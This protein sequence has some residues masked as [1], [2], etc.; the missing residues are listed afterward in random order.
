M[1]KLGY[2]GEEYYKYMLEREEKS[3]TYIGNNVAI[4]HGTLEGKAQVLK[5]GIV[6]NQYPEG[7]DFDG[8]KAYLLIGIAGKNNEHVDIISNIADVIEDEDKV[9]ELAKTKNIDDIYDVFSI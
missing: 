3:T 5:T 6:V 8:E 9:L 2:V 7:I 4:P 1:A